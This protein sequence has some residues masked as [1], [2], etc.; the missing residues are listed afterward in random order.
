MRTIVEELVTL[1]RPAVV[2]TVALPGSGKTTLLDRIV[3]DLR[4]TGLV[5]VV[6]PDSIR[7][8]LER[9]G[10]RQA[11]YQRA[12][13]NEVWGRVHKDAKAVLDLGGIA[14]IDATHLNEFREGA[15]QTY[16]D[17]GAKTVAALVLEMPLE[18]A[19]LRN[20]ARGAAGEGYVEPA[21]ID[22]MD[23][24]RQAHP[25]APDTPGAFD[26]VLRQPY[27]ESGT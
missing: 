1:E 16:R 8:E 7:D 3:P 14:I 25:L 26:M 10:R 4:L 17:L 21:D 24:F 13:N 12:S 27:I 2:M 18:V 5:E 15:V 23:A 19:K 11:R 6:C 9:V 22:K 20:E